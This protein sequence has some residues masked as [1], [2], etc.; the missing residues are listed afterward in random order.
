M[1]MN[2]TQSFMPHDKWFTNVLHGR[3]NFQN[4]MKL[5]LHARIYHSEFCGISAD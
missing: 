2:Q 3:K 1:N 5:Q 4:E